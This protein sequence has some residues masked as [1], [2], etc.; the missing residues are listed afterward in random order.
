MRKAIILILIIFPVLAF[1]QLEQAPDESKN[2]R[3]NTPR[4][5]GDLHEDSFFS[6]LRT[7]EEHDRLEKKRQIYQ[8]KLK[9]KRLKSNKNTR[10]GSTE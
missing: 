8:Q 3:E 1:A 7:A 6:H 10:K 4:M 5:V 9:E 2:N